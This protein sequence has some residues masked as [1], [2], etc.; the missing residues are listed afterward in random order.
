MSTPAD[1]REPSRRVGASNDQTRRHNLSTLLTILHHEGQQS[2]AQLTAQ[3]MLNRSTIAA[4]VT[5]LEALGLVV[6]GAA[7]ETNQVGRPSPVVHPTE[8][9]AVIAVNP[10]IDAITLG[11]VGFHGRVLHRVRHQTAGVP[12]VDE[13]VRISTREIE[14][15]TA[16]LGPR[17]RIAG[18]G[19]AVPGLVRATDGL[20]RFAPHL[21]WVDAPFAAL[22]AEATG[23]PVRSGNDASL[24]A[25]AERIF[26]AGR[27]IDDL[28]YLNGGASGIGGGI[29]AGG[30]PF[31]GAEGYAG[32]WGHITVSGPAGGGQSLEQ[33]VSQARLLAVLGLGPTGADELDRALR[34]AADRPELVAEVRRQLDVLG[35]ALRNA[36]NVLNPQLVIL[37][38]FLAALHAL[39]PGY[40]AERIEA[41]AL[42]APLDSVRIAE[43]G[44]GAD[45]LL[46]GA[47]ELAF[48]PLL[49]DP[50][51]FAQR[52]TESDA[53]VG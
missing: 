15:L 20:V 17:V 4:L 52:W 10:E 46:I 41:Q 2:R 6:E 22:L 14:R 47:A 53:A 48:E 8:E 32:E 38:G 1:R 51:A 50:A 39:A 7:A 36:V 26:G 19:V 42:R 44:L 40:L 21:D 43:A 27:G 25:L 31:G 13:A 37:G 3:T 24:G 12:T 30:R 34:A 5:E 16:E 29:I 23:L 9:L 18:V 35:V 28:M 49:A 45:L 33:Q 11:A